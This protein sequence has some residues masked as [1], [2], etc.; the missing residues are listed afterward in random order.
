MRFALALAQTTRR[1]R[2]RRRGREILGGLILGAVLVAGMILFPEWL[3]LLGCAYVGLVHVMCLWDTDVFLRMDDLRRFGLERFGLQTRLAYLGH[4]AASDWLLSHAIGLSLFTV[5]ALVLDE[6]QLLA[7]VAGLYVMALMPLPSVVRFGA[8]APA[9][10]VQVYIVLLLAALVGL[11]VIVVQAPDLLMD[12]PMR[13]AGILVLAGALQTLAMDAIAVRSSGSGLSSSDARRMLGWLVN[14]KPLLYKDLMLLWRPAVGT[15]LSSAAL[16][17]LLMIST[18]AAWA[19]P[20]AVV[21]LQE[22]V[23]MSKDRQGYRILQDDHFGMHIL[24]ADRTRLRRHLLRVLA[25]HPV[26]AWSIVLV[27]GLLTAAPLIHLLLAAL[28]MVAVHIVDVPRLLADMGRLGWWRVTVRYTLTVSFTLGV[29]I[30]GAAVSAVTVLIIVVTMLYAPSFRTAAALHRPHS[31][32]APLRS[33]HSDRM[34]VVPVPEAA[35]R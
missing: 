27:I 15:L 10:A 19:V 17:A 6:A 25:I 13:V 33:A 2:P 22:N 9:R 20:L 7:L 24:H 31:R 29:A 5:T 30:G 4:Y 11:G 28:V 3:I 18:P 34:D 21:C 1:R 35:L 12:S 16:F 8:R 32:T 14:R 26:L 23:F